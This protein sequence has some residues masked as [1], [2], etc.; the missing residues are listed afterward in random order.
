MFPLPPISKQATPPRASDVEQ[1]IQ[2]ITILH[3]VV[4]SFDAHL[5]LLFGTRFAATG[6]EV[7]IRDGLRADETLFE[8]GVDDAGGLRRGVALVDGPGAHFLHPGGEVGLQAEQFI[9]GADQAVEAGLFQTEVGEEFLLVGIVEVGQFLLDLGAQSHDGRAFFRCVF[10]QAVEVR[11]VFKTVFHHVADIHRWLDGEQAQ[12][13]DE[14]YLVIAQTE[15]ARGFSLVQVR[16]QFLQQG[17]QF[18]RVLVA[19]FGFLAITLD[20]AFHHSQIGQ[21]QFGE[22]D[23]DV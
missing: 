13:L 4:F 12:R 15:S 7:S 19:G 1:E 23:F 11:V 8:I 21:R 3:H 16:Q 20:G 14:L 18:L 22:D 10:A 9:A 5:A 6:D 2:Q 17:D